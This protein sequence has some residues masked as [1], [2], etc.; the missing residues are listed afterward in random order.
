MIAEPR[1][2]ADDG[3]PG[4]PG[5]IASA[6]CA[7]SGLLVT[8]LWTI[9]FFWAPFALLLVYSFGTQDYLTARMS[10]GW[11]LESWRAL[12]DPIVYNAF[13]RS[14]QLSTVAT[15]GCAII[16]YPLAYFVARH[17]G[18]Y[19]SLA[20]FLIVA[21]FWVS[22][23]VRAYAWIAI[24]GETGPVNHFFGWF[25]IGPFAL[26]NNNTGIAIGIVYSYLPLMVFPIFLAID[27]IDTEVLE[28]SRDL[29]ASPFATFRRVIFP[30]SLPGLVAGCTIVWIPALGEYVIPTVLGGGK[31]FMVGN[32]IGQYFTQ[33]FQWP[34]G[35]AL[36]AVLVLFALVALTVLLAVVRRGR[37][38]QAMSG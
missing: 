25:G 31:T 27:R 15:I 26:I 1:R 12:Y 4:L 10:F 34:L 11:T 32:V 8:L 20:L 37:W 14:V 19:R 28:A 7:Q 21:P 38:G 36:A 3:R 22:F 2:S 35:A 33:S 16:G 13:F 6:A 9:P 17:S 18:R 30:Q 24:L 5:R 23:I 29:G